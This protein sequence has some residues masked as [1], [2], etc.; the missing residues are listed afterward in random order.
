MVNIFVLVDFSP[1]VR[2]GPAPGSADGGE[3]EA[4]LDLALYVRDALRLDTSTDP[5]APPP[6]TNPPPDRSDLLDDADPVAVGEHWAAWWR[7]ALAFE[8]RW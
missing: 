4:S 8:A 1:D 2:V 3:R 7:T 6:L 5:L